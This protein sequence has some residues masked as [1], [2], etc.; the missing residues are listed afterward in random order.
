MLLEIAA[1]LIREEELEIPEE[2]Y[3][4]Y[5][6]CPAITDGSARQYPIGKYAIR[7]PFALFA[8]IL[9]IFLVSVF[10]GMNPNIP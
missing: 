3:V 7:K 1:S 10:D 4:V 2:S 5:A 8:R 9:N 6:L